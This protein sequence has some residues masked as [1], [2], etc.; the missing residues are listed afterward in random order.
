[1]GQPLQGIVRPL[2]LR[3]TS[4]ELV[5]HPTFKLVHMHVKRG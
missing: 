5:T 1:M 2:K 3:K 4:A